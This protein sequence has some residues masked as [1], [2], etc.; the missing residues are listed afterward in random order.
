M[1]SK[2]IK[3]SFIQALKYDVWE[4]AKYHG[5]QR[6]KKGTMMAEIIPIQCTT[7]AKRP[8]LTLNTTFLEVQ[9]V[10]CILSISIIMACL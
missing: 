5:L 10:S 3:K 4:S 2:L 1:Y 7:L 8:T 6:E 9:T